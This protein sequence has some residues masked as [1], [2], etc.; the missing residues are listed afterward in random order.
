MWRA[1]PEKMWPVTCRCRPLASCVS[2]PSWSTRKVPNS[3][4]SVAVSLSCKLHTHSSTCSSWNSSSPHMFLWRAE[5]PAV[6]QAGVRRCARRRRRRPRQGVAS[7]QR[8]RQRRRR[9]V[10]D[11]AAWPLPAA[12]AA[13][14]GGAD[15]GRARR[16]AA[17]PRAGLPAAAHG[18]PAGAKRLM[19]PGLSQPRCQEQLHSTRTDCWALRPVTVL[20]F[21][22]Q[23][24]WCANQEGCRSTNPNLHLRRRR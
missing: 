10:A 4:I 1:S 19:P 11:R 21:P 23:S 7:G 20:W 9:H 22:G 15:A 18:S 24:Q 5:V 12:A 14:H 3:Y 16:L 2:P 6:P 13:R 8:R 17:G